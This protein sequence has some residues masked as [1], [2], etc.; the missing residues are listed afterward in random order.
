MVIR[1]V[2]IVVSSNLLSSDISNSLLSHYSV[3]K[4]SLLLNVTMNDNN[5][6]R[7]AV[8]YYKF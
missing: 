2:S 3:M 5:Q 1:N 7:M 4:H 8:S 6:D